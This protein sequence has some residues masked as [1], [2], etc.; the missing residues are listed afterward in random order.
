MTIEKVKGSPC[1]RGKRGPYKL[2][3]RYRGLCAC[4]EHS[5]A[6]VTKGF[7]TFVSPEDA[8]HLMGMNWHAFRSGTAS[9]I[10][11]AAR[12][13]VPRKRRQHV[14]L[15]R[16]I[17]HTNDTDR[18]TDHIDHDGLNN[19]RNNLRPCSPS[20]NA[21][22]GRQRLG[23]SGF[24]GVTR[25]RKRWRVVIGKSRQHVGTFDTPEEA[26]RAYDVAAIERFGEFA[27]LNFPLNAAARGGAAVTGTAALPAAT[28]R[29]RYE[30]P[31]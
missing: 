7:V 8:H 1:P 21:G 27:T 13:V 20:E 2:P 10:Y 30:V 25:A 4:G 3:D 23:T 5:W 12:G 22:N 17:L 15:H 26:A 9:N 29:D 28:D 24:R 16:V 14:F 31:R 19:R 11:Y 18:D 6:I